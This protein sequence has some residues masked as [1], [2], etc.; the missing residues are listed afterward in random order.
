MIA[1]EVV[2]DG[3]LPEKLTTNIP[4]VTFTPLRD[5]LLSELEKHELVDDSMKIFDGKLRQLNQRTLSQRLIA[6]RDHYDLPTDKFP[7]DDLIGLT[8]ARNRIVHSGKGVE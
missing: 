1:L 8:K 2:V 4:K 7:D 3:V 5:V 6:L